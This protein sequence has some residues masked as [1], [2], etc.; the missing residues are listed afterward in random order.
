MG[1]GT[2]EEMNQRAKGD[3]NAMLNF[4]SHHFGEKTRQASGG[5]WVKHTSSDTDSELCLVISVL[6]ETR[7]LLG[8]GTLTL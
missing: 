2:M 3:H 7:V 4:S 6:T 8:R 1:V 5:C